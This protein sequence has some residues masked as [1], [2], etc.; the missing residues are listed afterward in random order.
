M[1]FRSSVAS[2]AAVAMLATACASGGGSAAPS[3]EEGNLPRDNSFT[4]TAQLFLV[5]AQQAETP[6]PARFQQVLDA[7]NQSIAEDSMNPLG[8]RLAGEANV[9]LNNYNEAARLFDQAV[10]LYPEYEEELR[11]VREA[12]WVQAYNAAIGPLRDGDLE[13]AQM[14]FENAH[15]IYAGRPEA[16]LQLAS[17]YERTNQTA[18]ALGMYEDV[19]DLV[20]GPRLAQQ[21]SAAQLDWAAQ[22]QIA[23]SLL[24]QGFSAQGRHADAVGAYQAYLENHPEN[25]QVASNMAGT[26]VLM[27]DTV[28]AR[29]VYA[30]LLT[31][32]GLSSREAF[33]IG[34]GYYNLEDYSQAAAAFKLSLDGNS[35]SRDGAYNYAQSLFLAEEYEPLADAGAHL[36]ELD[37]KNPNAYLLAGQGLLQA[38]QEDEANATAE[39]AGDLDFEVVRPTLTPIMG[40]G[41]RLNGVIKNNTLDANTVVSLRFHFTLDDGTES[42]TKDVTV[43]VG[44]TESET[45]F[46]TEA[47][48]TEPVVGFWYEVLRP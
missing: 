2:V 34:I 41:G 19:L 45:A 1:T 23:S 47:D 42:S 15:V 28:A 37:P 31:R 29:G 10:E 12:A 46:D 24:A 43:Q 18:E 6:D 44:E 16:M 14:Q 39:M 48:A 32:P 3:A 20:T 30:D 25:V 9:G 33:S 22:E 26:M 27:G 17:L 5:Q 38:G 40:G 8:Y 7:A 35:M 13:E 4:Q 36:I 21:D 11:F